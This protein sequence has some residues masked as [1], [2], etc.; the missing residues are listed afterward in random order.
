MAAE[1]EQRVVIRWRVRGQAEAL[2]PSLGE[3]FPVNE[4]ACFVKALRAIDEAERG[5]WGSGEPSGDEPA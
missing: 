1:R 2:S 3:A 4:E 5:V